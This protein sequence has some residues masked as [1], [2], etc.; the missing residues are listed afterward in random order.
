MANT[1]PNYGWQLPEV[2]SPVDE[3]LWGGELNQNLS[4]QDTQ[5]FAIQKNAM[6]A[7]TD[8]ASAATVNIG[9]E[10]TANL[11][12]TGTT[13]ISAF[14]TADSGTVRWLRFAAA[15][16]LTHNATSLI[17]PGAANIT[18]A[19]GDTCCVKSLGSGNWVC[20]F[21]Q[22]ASGAAVVNPD[23][24]TTVKGVVE[25]ATDAEV[26]TGT[27]T[28]LVPPVSAVNAHLGV[29]KAWVV[30]TVSGGVL[31]VQD[32]HNCT[33]SR[34]STGQ[35]TV[36][37]TT[38]FANQYYVVSGGVRRGSSDNNIIWAIDL[39]SAPTATDCYIACVGGGSTTPVD[40]SYGSFVF[41]GR[42]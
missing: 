32:S 2:G 38:P 26:T 41:H 40:V 13:A 35:Y 25:L 16:T 24:S 3:D 31:T 12:V 17:L 8:I 29:A 34:S 42:Q 33:A 9:A 7:W 28:T 14:D 5:V 1:T 19:A 23:A 39:A 4:D 6:G 18:T 15:L 21:Y 27:S 10:T 22:K 37:F 30:F 11:R 20:L 36:T